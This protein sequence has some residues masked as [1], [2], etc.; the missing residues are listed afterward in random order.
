MYI[1]RFHLVE[2][3]DPP[4]PAIV[5]EHP[6]RIPLGRLRLSL[7]SECFGA[8]PELQR[9]RLLATWTATQWPYRIEQQAM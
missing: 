3:I 2:G 8:M 9:V 5:H 6:D 1:V 4:P 7:P